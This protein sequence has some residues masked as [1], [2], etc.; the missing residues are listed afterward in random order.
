MVA[1]SG[2]EIEA[3]RGHVHVEAGHVDEATSFIWQWS[4]FALRQA[5]AAGAVTEAEG[6][7]CDRDA[8]ADKGRLGLLFG[9]V[10]YISV[11]ARR[12]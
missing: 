10:N 7:A 2:V 9:S 3:V 4:L 1:G 8:A 11:F 6:A 12:P 5:L